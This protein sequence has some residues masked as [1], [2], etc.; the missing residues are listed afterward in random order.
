[1]QNYVT[2]N[3]DY[4]NFN[5]GGSGVGVR[6]DGGLGGGGH[7][8]ISGNAE[9]TAGTANTGGGGGGSVVGSSAAGGSGIVIIKYKYKSADY[10]PYM[11]A[12]GGTVSYDGNYKIHSFLLADTGTDFTVTHEG[13][14]PNVEYLV[15]AGG[16]GGGHGDICSG[17]GGA[18]GMRYNGAYDHAVSEQAYTITVGDG[19]DGGSNGGFT[20]GESGENSVFDTITSTGGGG[21]GSVLSPHT[22][23]D[24]VAGGSGGGAEY[25][26][27]GGTSTAY[28]NNGGTSVTSSKYGGGG[29]GVPGLLVLMELQ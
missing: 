3:I 17:G 1:M 28:G 5:R 4:V 25:N 29:G 20:W 7:G 18:G 9:I 6:G 24:G 15:V 22:W 27:S 2:L 19:G 26:G 21:G 12:T 16:G 23:K 13:G 11:T 8:A 14:F 10:E